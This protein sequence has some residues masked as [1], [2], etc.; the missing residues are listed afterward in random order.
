MTAQA[1]VFIVLLRVDL[2]C[3][4]RFCGCCEASRG[5]NFTIRNVDVRR[6]DVLADWLQGSVLWPVLGGQLTAVFCVHCVRTGW[7]QNSD[8]RQLTRTIIK[9]DNLIFCNIILR[10]SWLHT[11]FWQLWA[12]R[13]VELDTRNQNVVPNGVFIWLVWDVAGLEAEGVQCGSGGLAVNIDTA[14]ITFD[15]AVQTFCCPTAVM[16]KICLCGEV[17]GMEEGA[18]SMQTK[19][20]ARLLSVCW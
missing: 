3:T 10:G 15:P 16:W 14:G 13:T 7:E 4:Q 11:D 8:S 5:W 17:M 9:T 2:L 20:V 19:D 6:P 18:C 12:V 1:V